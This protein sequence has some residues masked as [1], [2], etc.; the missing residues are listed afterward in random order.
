[1]SLLMLSYRSRTRYTEGTRQRNTSC[2][3]PQSLS[4]FGTYEDETAARF[5]KLPSGLRHRQNAQLKVGAWV[6]NITFARFC[7]LGIRAGACRLNK[8]SNKICFAFLAFYNHRR[9]TLSVFERGQLQHRRK[10]SI[11]AYHNEYWS[12]STCRS[13]MHNCNV[14][15]KLTKLNWKKNLRVI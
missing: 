2:S 10:S 5:K 15:S 1:M 11:S 14:H 9:V 8:T 7:H 6:D 12:R 3:P 4:I 13:K